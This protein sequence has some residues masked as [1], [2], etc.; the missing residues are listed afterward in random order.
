M[1]GTIGTIEISGTIETMGTME[2]INTIGI[3]GDQLPNK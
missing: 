1:I 2:T 3:V